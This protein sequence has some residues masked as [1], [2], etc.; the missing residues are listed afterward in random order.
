MRGN[1]KI[2]REK[3]WKR[4]EKIDKKEKGYIQKRNNGIKGMRKKMEHEK[5]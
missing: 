1:K 2:K 3:K 5:E 4:Y